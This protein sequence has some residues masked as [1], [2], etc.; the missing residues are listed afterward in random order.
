MGQGMSNEESAALRVL[1]VDDHAIVRRGIAAYLEVL[2]DIETV[3]Q[4]E[5]GRVA[6]E[7]LAELATF[8]SL[9]DL[10][11]L[12]LIMPVMDG[13]KTL[14]QIKEK[15]PSVKVVILTSFGEPERLHEALRQG[16]RGYLLKD[17]GP[18]DVAAAIRAAARDEVYI[19]PALALDLTKS[20]ASPPTGISTLTERERDVLV[21]VAEGHS[22]QDI[23]GNLGISERTAR[24]HVSNVL[25]KLGVS[26]RTQ[27]A[28][29]AVNAGLVSP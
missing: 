5:N 7:R 17:A 19:D 25:G 24:T 15:Y 10:V 3:G 21:L 11:L 29:T 2:D 4:A 14:K 22:N 26:S 12:D 6:L 27:A 13:M 16:A 8:E 18:E 28:L 1:I 23:A 9:P 20:F